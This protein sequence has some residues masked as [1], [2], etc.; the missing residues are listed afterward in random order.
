MD[1]K[2]LI[3]EIKRMKFENACYRVMEAGNYFL[4]SY[5]ELQEYAKK[6]IDDFA[7]NCAINVLEALKE[8]CTFYKYDYSMGTLETPTPILTFDELIDLIDESYEEEE[9]A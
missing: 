9:E 7:Y 8:G 1:N 3:K 6:K 5:E 2:K 4:T